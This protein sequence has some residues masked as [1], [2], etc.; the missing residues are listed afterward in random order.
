MAFMLGENL[1]FIDSIDMYDS[2]LWIMAYKTWLKT[3]SKLNS[4]TCLS[5][6]VEKIE[7]VKQKEIYL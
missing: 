4:N 7:L 6:L 2:N 5:N 3:F 1:V